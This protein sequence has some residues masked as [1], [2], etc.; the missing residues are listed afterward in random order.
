MKQAKNT[1]A[2]GSKHFVLD[3]TKEHIKS[4]NFIGFFQ[5]QT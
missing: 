2:Y 1:P 4:N 3:L 5:N